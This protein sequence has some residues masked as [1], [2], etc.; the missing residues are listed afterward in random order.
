MNDYAV[1]LQHASM[2]AAEAHNKAAIFDRL[3]EA[4]GEVGLSN[5]A[6]FAFFVP[7]RIE[8]FGKH[9]DYAGGRSLLCCVERGFCFL[10]WRRKDR[11][12]RFLETA[13][14][15]RIAEWE[16]SSKTGIVDPHWALYP[17]TVSRRV[18]RNF[19]SARFGADVI[20]SSDLPRAS[21]LS[22]SSAF[23]VGSFL[24]LA[25]ANDLSETEEYKQ[26]LPDCEH[27]AAYL[28]AVENGSTFRSLE[29][30]E[31]VGTLG[32]SEDHTAVLYSHAGQLSQYAFRPV[33]HERSIALPAGVSF[34]IASSGVAADKTGFAQGQY[35]R[36]SQLARTVLD[37]WNQKR[38][39]NDKSLA[40]AVDSC[41]GAREQIRDLILESPGDPKALLARFEHFLRES[42]ELVPEAGNALSL[43]DWARFGELAAQSQEAAECLLGNQIPETSFLARSAREC[44]AYAA[45]AFGAGFGGSV[46]ALVPSGIMN[47]F[48]QSWGEAYRRKF[49][50]YDRAAF[51]ETGAGP[52]A[53]SLDGNVYELRRRRPAPMREY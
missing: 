39:R 17:V 24:A 11:K 22:S 18:C 16:L 10:C 38:A 30:D 43:R 25:A 26:N 5:A 44:G 37:L 20:F 7:G 53:L 47:Q 19:P 21:G 6:D 51:F 23:V 13:N 52:A 46:W 4:A 50:D 9:T 29:G 48:V 41:I 14:D 35:N 45:S 27:L 12:I 3:R 33:R 49:P 42:Y 15:R 36:A 40:A 1:V 34:V 8:L 28:G 2:S 32:G 31:G